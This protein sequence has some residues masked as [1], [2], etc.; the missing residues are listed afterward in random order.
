M[1]PNWTLFPTAIHWM[2]RLAIAF[3]AITAAAVLVTLTNNAVCR[4]VCHGQAEG[5]S[6]LNALL[7]GLAAIL[8]IFVPQAACR[9]S[10]ATR[11]VSW[12]AIIFGFIAALFFGPLAPRLSS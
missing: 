8:G 1:I 6:N 3:A 12:I 4:V 2:A 11:I 5:F 7:G 10:R 9:D